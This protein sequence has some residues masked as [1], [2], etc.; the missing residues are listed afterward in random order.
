LNFVPKGKTDEDYI[1]RVSLINERTKE[2]FSDTL[3]FIY[4]ILPKFNKTLEEL[5]D[6]LDC[7]LYILKHS[8]KMELQPEEIRKEFFIRFLE[9]IKVK[10]LKG[11][12]MKA[13]RNSEL[14]YEDLYNFTSF[15]K[16]EGKEEGLMEGEEKGKKESK[17]QISKELL[18]MGMSISDISK[19]TGLAPQQI[20]LLH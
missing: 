15:A 8:K 9:Y 12:N 5:E 11:K 10:Q 18:K 14:R 2:P 19:A 17:F 6:D 3:N 4:I 20:Q 16:M 1:E 13:Y 7:W